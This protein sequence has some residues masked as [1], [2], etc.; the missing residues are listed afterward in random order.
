MSR[1]RKLRIIAAIG[2]LLSGPVCAE[3]L[4]PKPDPAQGDGRVGPFYS[5]TNAIP[6]RPGEILR[7]E[8]LQALLGLPEAGMQARILYSSTDGIDDKT[9]VVVSGAFFA[10]KGAPPPGGWPLVAWAHGTVGVA[11]I[12][13]PSWQTRSFRDMEY[14]GTWLREGFA[15]VATDYQGL[16]V[17]GPHPYL[18]VRPEAYS[19]LDAIRAARKAYPDV[20]TKVIVVGQ[21][22][23]GGAA[24]A[25]AA[26]AP[27][28]APEIDIRGTVA[29]GIPF[30]TAETLRHVSPHPEEV[31]PTIAYALYLALFAQQVDPAFDP[32][33]L[34]TD[35]GLEVLK[36]A[37][38]T[39]VGALFTDA[40]AAGLSDSTTYRKSPDRAMASV[41]QYLTY[42]TLKLR[43]PLFVGTGAA[44]HDVPPAM[45]KRLVQEACAAGTVV[46]A[47]LYAGLDHSGTVNASLADSLPFVRRVLAGE[48]ITPQCD[49]QPQ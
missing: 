9:P 42:P 39:C 10:P 38:N 41:M 8:A 30:I 19:V 25:A 6:E 21:S 29:T 45:Q 36:L 26:F 7:T 40:R 12:C 33:A 32:A 16:G 1:T 43:Q 46:Q 20:G 35:R 37:R 13:A 47:R 17:P 34:F 22:Q 27:D 49:P 4:A 2:L 11:D 31:R 23:G 44:D 5:W 15:V 24:F 48:P 3:T 28:Y 14:L 18:A